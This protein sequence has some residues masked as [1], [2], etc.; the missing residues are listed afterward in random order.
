ME[1][2]LKCFRQQKSD[3]QG[4]TLIELLVVVVIM[5]IL[6][7]IGLP[8][9]LAQAG[10]ANQARA[11]NS[12]GAINRAQQAY[13]MEKAAFATSLNDLAIGNLNLEGY[14]LDIQVTLTEAKA[15]AAPSRV[16][17]I[18]YC[19]IVSTTGSGNQALTTATLSSGTCP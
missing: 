10:K 15:E 17:L 8:S 5:G 13:F 3:E 6:A 19:G 9:M 2:L 18:A 14:V 12:I 11:Q 4:F 1:T 7:G 16:G